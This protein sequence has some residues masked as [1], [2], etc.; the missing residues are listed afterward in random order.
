MTN[1][2][3][4][5]KTDGRRGKVRADTGSCSRPGHASRRKN[6]GAS[7]LRIVRDV[8]AMDDVNRRV[9]FRRF[10][11]DEDGIPSRQS[12]LVLSKLPED[13]AQ[14]IGENSSERILTWTRR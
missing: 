12:V 13:Q 3:W 14:T 10:D 1:A 7:A 5:I 2:V 9:V 6:N 11:G 8:L 4:I